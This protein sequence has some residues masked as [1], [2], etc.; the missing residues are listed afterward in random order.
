MLFHGGVPGKQPGE[1]LRGGGGT[2]PVHDGCPIC[3]ARA[4]GLAVSVGGH[5][6]DGPS[7]REHMV[8]VTSDKEYA[9]YYASLYGRGDLYQVAPLG[10]LEPSTED[11]FPTWTTPAVR[12]VAAYARAVLLTWQQR[13]RLLA[14]WAEADRRALESR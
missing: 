5:M 7:F 11:H 13:R 12:V 10:P 8:Y 4:R 14:R 6:I 1:I 2:R 3:A 9:R